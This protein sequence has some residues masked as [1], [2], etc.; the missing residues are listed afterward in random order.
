MNALL[1]IDHGSRRAESNARL[2]SLASSLAERLDGV[3]VVAAHL[4]LAQPSIADGFARCAE[5]GATHIVVHPFFLGPGRHATVDV[6]DQVRAASVEHPEIS[7]AIT[8]PLGQSPD[9]LDVIIKSYDAA[10]R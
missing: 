1:V 4:E 2:E 6:P 7:Y 10:A 3:I 9:L 8:D 5:L